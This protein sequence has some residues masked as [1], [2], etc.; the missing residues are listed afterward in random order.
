MPGRPNKPTQERIDR[1]YRELRAADPDEL[2]RCVERAT[3]ISLNHG[4][5][6]ALPE[7]VV[8]IELVVDIE[9]SLVE[10]AIRNRG[11]RGGW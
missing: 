10:C 9:L 11:H 5:A 6:Q 2:R 7:G 8:L 3:A 4:L 1:A